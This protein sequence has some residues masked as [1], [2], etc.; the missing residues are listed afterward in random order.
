MIIFLWVYNFNNN[1]NVYSA[2]FKNFVQIQKRRFYFINCFI[3]LLVYYTEF[4]TQLYFM[5]NKKEFFLY[6]L[7][8]IMSFV[9]KSIF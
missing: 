7:I 3:M 5:N 9:F 4:V 8:K 6:E 2:V 1:S